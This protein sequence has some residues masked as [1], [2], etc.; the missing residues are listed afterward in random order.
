MLLESWLPACNKDAIEL[1]SELD[2][3]E[4]S[5]HAELALDALLQ[6]GADKNTKQPPYSR[7]ELNAERAL[8]WRMRVAVLVG[9]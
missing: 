6:S 1:L 5:M 4:H 2:V 9:F 8:Y 3:R 7:K